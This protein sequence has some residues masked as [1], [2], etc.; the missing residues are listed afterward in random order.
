MV[1]DQ[2]MMYT[3]YYRISNVFISSNVTSGHLWENEGSVN[4][5]CS[6][7]G[8]DPIFS[9]TFNGGALPQDPRYQLSPDGSS[10]V[11]SPV[12][13]RD[14]GPF[15]CSASN[16]AFTQSSQP[17]LLTISYPISNV[18]ISSNLTSG[19]L[20]EN[21][22]SV[23]LT[24]S[25][26]GTDPIFSW[27]FNGSA[28][29][30]DPRYHL[31]PDGSSLVINPVTR[32][33]TGPFVCSASN[34]ANTQSSQP[35]LLSISLRPSGGIQCGAQSISDSHVELSCSWT[36]GSPPA[37]VQLQL[38]PSIDAGAN[39]EVKRNVSRSDITPSMTLTCRG[40]QEGYTDNCSLALGLPED[41][42]FKDNTT[43]PVTAGQPV[44]LVV[45]LVS[46]SRVSSAGVLPAT[47]TWFNGTSSVAS[48]GR[49]EITS[50]ASFSQMMIA[51]AMESDSGDYVC[52][53]ENLMGATSF[54][55]R[56][57]V[58]PAPEPPITPGG[59]SA[60]A[61]AGIVVGVLAVVVIVGVTVYFVLKKKKD[62]VARSEDRAN[63]GRPKED[64]SH[65]ST[66]LENVGEKAQ[67]YYVNVDTRAAEHRYETLIRETA[68]H[69]YETLFPK[70]A[71]PDYSNIN[72]KKTPR[73]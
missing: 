36:G 11:I 53:A 43:L 55:F 28:L 5:T 7:L 12:T 13:R 56:V 35:L 60:G 26:L 30:Q 51:N 52:R 45:N 42:G 8:M 27:T 3:N 4:L 63:T 59:L 25:A 71:A 70:T 2:F 47:F 40:A 41:P 21:E 73:V 50:N 34:P 58:S 62:K 61:I 37:N 69:R 14:A 1:C 57:H 65:Y 20:W 24:C 19:H 49:V 46:C 17:L 38:P 68:E 18:F 16:P 67:P 15:V 66:V 9:W 33:D 10:L 54:S 29:P 23:N 64:G 31:S 32:R 22:G 39:N 6:A 44:V 48:G 72:V